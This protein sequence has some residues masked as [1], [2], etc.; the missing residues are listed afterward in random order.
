[1][2]LSFVNDSLVKGKAVFF[3]PIKKFNLDIGFKKIKKDS[4]SSFSHERRQTSIWGN[5]A[6]KK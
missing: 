3:D 2:Q 5:F 1:M 4:E 6:G